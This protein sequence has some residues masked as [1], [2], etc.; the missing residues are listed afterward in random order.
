MNDAIFNSRWQW[1]LAYGPRKIAP[2]PA[3]FLR[4]AVYALK[5]AF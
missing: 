2:D 1:H 5:Q 3:Q 4:S